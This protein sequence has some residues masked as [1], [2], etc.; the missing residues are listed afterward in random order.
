MYF[1][2]TGYRWRHVSEELSLQDPK[3]YSL[4]SRKVEAIE[5]H[6][7]G[8]RRDKILDRT[9]PAHPSFRR[10]P[11]RRR[12]VRRCRRHARSRDSGD[13]PADSPA[14]VLLQVVAALRSLQAPSCPLESSLRCLGGERRVVRGPALRRRAARS[15]GPLPP[16]GGAAPVEF[17]CGDTSRGIPADDAT[18]LARARECGSV[19]GPSTSSMRPQARQVK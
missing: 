5:V 14:K 6:H 16:A 18:R 13:W 12:E 9:S 2:K 17:L 8:P 7:L 11:R 4:R 19:S 3:A 10:T 1:L 15:A